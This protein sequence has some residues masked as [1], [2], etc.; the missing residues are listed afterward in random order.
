MTEYF[1]IAMTPTIVDLQVD[2]GSRE[3]YA[4]AGEG[5][6]DPA[7]DRHELT[8]QEVAL[9]TT[10]DSFYLASV[11]ETGWPYVQHR[12]G[13]RGFVHLI[14]GHTI[15]WL[16]RNGNRQYLG[17]GNI[18][19]TGRI[20]AIF[21]DYPS[22]TRLKLYGMAT[23]HANPSPELLHSLEA[24]KVRSDAAITVEVLATNWN[25]PKYITPRFTEPEVREATQQLELRIVELEA[26][27]AE[28][29]DA[30]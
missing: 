26:K 10:R 21:V 24:D 29:N 27:L 4:G 7:T 28:R 6:V 13:D 22:R 9:L 20:A 19:A 1:D 16:E 30:I 15:G 14:S 25:C 23:H 12:G 3:L 11:S 2:K 18:A 5:R 17:T 8:V